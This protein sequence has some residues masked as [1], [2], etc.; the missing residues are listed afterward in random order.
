MNLLAVN[1]RLD[2]N[3]QRPGANIAGRSDAARGKAPPREIFDATAEWAEV[4]ELASRH[5]FLDGKEEEGSSAADVD[6]G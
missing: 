2:T 4:R 3:D 6:E 5:G 1:S